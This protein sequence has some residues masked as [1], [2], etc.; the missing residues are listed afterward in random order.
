MSRNGKKQTKDT[1]AI[2]S[3]LRSKGYHDVQAY[4]ENWASI[5]IRVIDARFKGKS[6]VQREKMVLPIVRSLP[7]EIQMD[8]TLLLLITPD[9]KDDSLTN[10]EFEAPTPSRL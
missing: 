6:R 1:R 5:R 7:N 3:L 8:L 2:E 9:E 4:R 10:M